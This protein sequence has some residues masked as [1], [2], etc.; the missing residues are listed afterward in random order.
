M[1]S[2]ELASV[3]EIIIMS[4]HVGKSTLIKEPLLFPSNNGRQ[5]IALSR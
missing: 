5:K 4:W 2:N 3:N 1:D